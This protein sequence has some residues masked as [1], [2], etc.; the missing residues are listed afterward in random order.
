MTYRPWTL[1]LRE[2]ITGCS[3]TFGPRKLSLL[4]LCPGA[5][6]LLQGAHFRSTAST[7]ALLHARAALQQGLW[8]GGGKDV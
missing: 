4:R 3:T 5:L 2:E 1:R 8:G 7:E 6:S